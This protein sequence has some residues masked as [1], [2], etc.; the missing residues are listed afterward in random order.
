MCQQNRY[1]SVLSALNKSNRVIAGSFGLGIGMI[2]H[3]NQLP[4]PFDLNGYEHGL[5]MGSGWPNSP[6][7]GCHSTGLKPAPMQIDTPRTRIQRLGFGFI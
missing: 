7:K 5:T 6:C 4:I 1:D 3:I 2:T